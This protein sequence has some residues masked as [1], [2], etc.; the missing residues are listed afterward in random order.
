MTDLDFIREQVTS[1]YSGEVLYELPAPRSNIDSITM[2]RGYCAENLC[3]NYGTSC[4]CPPNSHSPD[5][6]IKRLHSFNKAMLIIKR[7]LVDYRDKEKMESCLTD[8]QSICR[9]I[10]VSL[11]GRGIRN[12]PL[13]NGPCRYCANCVCDAESNCRFPNFK[14]GSV[15][16]YG[17]LVNEYLESVGITAEPVGGD[18]V[19]LYAFIFYD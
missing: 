2:S 3:G 5:E 14:I 16:P 9:D 10:H 8:I 12:L 13:A 6:C 17:I 15:S 1:V 7:Y 4:T 18:T 11:S 19:A